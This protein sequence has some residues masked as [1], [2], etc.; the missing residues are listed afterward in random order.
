LPRQA[1][2]EE[3]EEEEEEGGFSC[4]VM[5]TGHLYILQKKAL[6]DFFVLVYTLIFKLGSI[7]ILQLPTTTLSSFHHP[8]LRSAGDDARI[9]DWRWITFAFLSFCPNYESGKVQLD[10]VDP[11]S[12]AVLQ[13]VS[14]GARGKFLLPLHGVD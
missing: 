14:Q 4:I 11:R 10:D 2:E 5:G 13:L 1:E 6:I 3:E 9:P 8:R 12:F 7:L